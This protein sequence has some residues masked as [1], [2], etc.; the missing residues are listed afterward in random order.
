[1]RNTQL[2]SAIGDIPWLECAPQLW[3]IDDLDEGRA[4]LL[5]A[6]LHRAQAGPP[7]TCATCGELLEAQF[8]Q[9]W[10]CGSARPP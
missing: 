5:L 9:C 10:K 6:E 2:A 3:V 4:R 8:G 7:W 1:V